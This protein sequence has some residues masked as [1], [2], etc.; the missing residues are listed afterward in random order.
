MKHIQPGSAASTL[1]V[2]KLGGSLFDTPDLRQR[3]NG[4]LAEQPPGIVLLAGGGEWA[5]AVRR[6]DKQFGLE[7][8]TAH[9]LAVSAM[10]TTARLLAALVPSA[11]FVDQW[12]NDVI[13]LAAERATILDPW[14]FLRADANGA[15]GEPLP[16]S[17][18]VTSDSI[19]ARLVGVLVRRELVL[20]KSC[21]VPADLSPPALAK[22]GLVDD[23]FPQAAA[24]L[25][26]RW[27]NLRAAAA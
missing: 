20:M 26:V 24:G 2:V 14:E 7:E 3:L 18:T 9:W 5:E 6:A 10:R 23:Y 8:E 1:A 11:A 16:Q 17:W 4:W 21:P 15:F 25:I 13:L 19:A 27:V 12:P 22:L